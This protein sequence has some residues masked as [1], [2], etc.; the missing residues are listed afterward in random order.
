MQTAP[1]KVIRAWTMYDWANSAYSL[2]ITTVIFPT[3]FTAIAPERVQLFGRTF[4]RTPLASYT[5]ALSFLI[6]ALISPILSS[7][8]DYKGNKLAFMKFFCYL[9]SA[10]CIGLTFL[11]K[12]TIPLGIFFSIIGSIGFAGSIVF[13]NAYLPEI[14]AEEDQDRISAKGFSMGYIGSVILMAVC[15]AFIMANESMDLG[16]GDWPVRLAFLGVGLWWAGFAQITFR[17]LPPS[18]PSDQHPEHSIFV[19]GFYEL[20]KVWDQL[21]HT[22]ATKR[23]LRSFFFYNMGVQTVMYMATYFAADEL[24]MKGSA[25]IIT[26]VIIQLVGVLGAIVFSRLS[27]RTSNL[28]TLGLIIMIWIGICIGAYFVQTSLQFYILAFCVGMVMGGVQSLSRST[29]SKLLPPTK[30]TASYFSFYDVSERVGT[31]LGTLAFGYVAELLGM[32]YSVLALMA[33]FIIGGVLLLF[34]DPKRRTFAT[35]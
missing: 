7:I 26:L 34:V 2:V 12:D 21:K 6:I 35:R 25:L 8:A 10:A 4:E 20:R 30:D 17:N 29:Y 16:W 27:Q 24:G 23:F 14:A 9:G 19:N 31:F 15:L 28:F 18:I 33:F 13:Y 22:P 11:T 32:R 3:Y 5:V 1:K